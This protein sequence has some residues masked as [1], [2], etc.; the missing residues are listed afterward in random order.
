MFNPLILDA[1]YGVNQFVE[2]QLLPYQTCVGTDEMLDLLRY[3]QESGN[4]YW[5]GVAFPGQSDTTIGAGVTANGTIQVPA[6]TYVIGMTYYASNEA[7]MKF[8]LYDKGTKASIFY[9]DYCLD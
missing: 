2:N 1:P 6:G 7:G 8:K 3:I 9:G 5:Q 4:Y